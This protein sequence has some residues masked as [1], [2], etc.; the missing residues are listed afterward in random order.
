[1][2]SPGGQEKV[3]ELV[4]PGASFA[5]ALVFLG[6]PCLVNAQVLADSLLLSV[7]RETIVTE[8]QRDDR[9]AMRMLAGLSGGCMG[10]CTTC[11]PTRCRTACSV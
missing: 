11:R 5:E 8:I 7:A 3:I 2:I 9:L 6:R 1:M 10:W 4:G